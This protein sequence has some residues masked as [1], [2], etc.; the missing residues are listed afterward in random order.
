[1]TAA[2]KPAPDQVALIASAPSHP[3]S[4]S[5]SIILVTITQDTVTTIRGNI[6]TY[7]ELKAADPTLNCLEFDDDVTALNHNYE[8]PDYNPHPTPAPADALDGAREKLDTLE[9]IS[10]TAQEEGTFTL[11][12]NGTY[13]T[14]D[15]LQSITMEADTVRRVI[16]S[17]GVHWEGFVAADSTAWETRTLSFTEV[18]TLATTQ[19]VFA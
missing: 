7:Q 6:K 19:E 2:D 10:K 11:L 15:E 16:T 5:P 13:F 14:P 4:E 1:M 8:D 18:D 3:E 12:R 17:R 9:E